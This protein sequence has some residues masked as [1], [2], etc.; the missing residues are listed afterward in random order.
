[1]FSLVINSTKLTFLILIFILVSVGCGFHIVITDPE[2]DYIKICDDKECNAEKINQKSQFLLKIR[3][4]KA[5]YGTVVASHW[6]YLD[7][8]KEILL[9]DKITDLEKPRF[10]IHGLRI[11][12]TGYWK[13]G[14]YRVDVDINGKKYKSIT[15][16]V[17]RKFP[18]KPIKSDI[19]NSVSPATKGDSD[20][21]MD[22]DF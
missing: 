7:K 22:D 2:V 19:K 21:I 11:P 17:P 12:R 14:K 9:R 13:S 10:F 6:Y 8:T 3:M 1:M 5:P 18:N 16:Q 4:K 20:D 15:F